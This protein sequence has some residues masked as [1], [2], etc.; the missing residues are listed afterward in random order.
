MASN[1]RRDSSCCK[2]T[3]EAIAYNIHEHYFTRATLPSELGGEGRGEGRQ[4]LG[5]EDDS[6]EM[7]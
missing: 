1:L 6:Q 5:G 3:H 2:L 4:V 7:E